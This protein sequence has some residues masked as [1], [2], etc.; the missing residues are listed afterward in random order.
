[1]VIRGSKM[2]WVNGISQIGLGKI[3]FIITMIALTNFFD[4]TSYSARLTGVRTKKLAI[5]NSLFA[6]LTFGSRTT[7]ALYVAPIGGIIDRAIHQQFNPLII[8]Q[9]VLLGATI[10]TAI[11]ILF[12]P[13]ITKFYDL[14][15]NRMD[16]HETAMKVFK[17]LFL[18][19]EGLREVAQ[20]WLRP[21]IH[22]LKGISLTNVPKS[23][24]FLNAVLYSFFTVG[25]IASFYGAWLQPQYMDAC[26]KLIYCN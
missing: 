3:I 19:K 6:M 22:M 2:E 7:T 8:L 25:S 15:I 18:T 12:M 26:N 24:I 17:S 21:R 13:T 16:Q 9:V 23:M 4:T 5:S 1:V 10:G 11:A 14:G 20:C